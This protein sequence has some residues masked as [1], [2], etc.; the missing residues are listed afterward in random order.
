MSVV[1]GALAGVM[2]S[3]YG[4]VGAMS[5]AAVLV[6]AESPGPSRN[7]R[8]G[9]VAAGWPSAASKKSQI[10]PKCTSMS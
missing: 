2:P 5:V 6:G 7:C 3:R 10:S 1:E 8:D 9:D 4:L